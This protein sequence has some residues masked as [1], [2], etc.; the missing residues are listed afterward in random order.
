[1]IQ[2]SLI[3][4]LVYFFEISTD[5]VEYKIYVKK[6]AVISKIKINLRTIDHIVQILYER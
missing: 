5:H 4:V 3:L 1:M 6:K 2:P